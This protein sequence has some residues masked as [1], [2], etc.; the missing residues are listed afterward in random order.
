ML[1][2]SSD[3]L[4]EGRQLIIPATAGHI[5][6]LKV[7]PS[8]IPVTADRGQGEDTRAWAHDAHFHKQIDVVLRFGLHRTAA[9]KQSRD[10]I[11]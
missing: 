6:A 8:Y 3:A 9:Q 2:P 7:P 5:P 1:I 4:L 10:P 11:L